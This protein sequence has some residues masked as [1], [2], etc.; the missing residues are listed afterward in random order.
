[1]PLQLLSRVV[2]AAV[3]AAGCAVCVLTYV[4]RV[5]LKDAFATYIAQV[6]AQ[7]RSGG[8]GAARRP[9]A[10]TLHKLR[11]SDSALNPNVLRDTGIA[12]SL[13]HLGRGAE[14]ERTMLRAVRREPGNVNAWATLTQVQV[15]RHRIAAA[16][17]SYA[18]AR[19]L[20]PHLPPGLPPPV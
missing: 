4:S 9:F 18:R 14:S 15:A 17:R 12:I 16:R 5:Q 20:D 11:D 6:S 19:Q 8:P 7:P 3:C 2:L 10:V 13:L 1:M